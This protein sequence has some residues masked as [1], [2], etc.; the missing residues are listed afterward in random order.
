MPG[1]IM[2]PFPFCCGPYSAASINRTSP[3][4][5]I[6]FRRRTRGAGQNEDQG[7]GADGRVQR[8][9]SAPVLDK[10]R[11]PAEVLRSTGPPGLGKVSVAGQPAVG[12]SPARRIVLSG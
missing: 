1:S 7:G 5:A 2:P 8:E 3:A 4:S 10:N 9:T 11:C 6:R 12:R